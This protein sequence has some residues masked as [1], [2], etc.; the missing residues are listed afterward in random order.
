MSIIQKSSII[1][2]ILKN[3]EFDF[4]VEYG[5]EGIDYEVGR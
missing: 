5:L 1:S 2:L 3:G 4:K